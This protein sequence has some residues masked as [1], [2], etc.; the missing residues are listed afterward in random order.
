MCQQRHSFSSQVVGME[1]KE[2][3]SRFAE[4][5]S[6]DFVLML[7]PDALVPLEKANGIILHFEVDD[8]TEA[9][10]HAVEKGATVLL[11][12]TQTDWGTAV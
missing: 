2:S 4:L 11:G 5:V 3:S 7:S 10:S 8:V 9:L 6:D 1:L 12:Y